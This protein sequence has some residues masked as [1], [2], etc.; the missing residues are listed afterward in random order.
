MQR[1]CDI[2]THLLWVF[3]IQK[4]MNSTLFSLWLVPL[5]WSK[6]KLLHSVD[7]RSRRENSLRNKTKLEAATRLQYVKIWYFI[8]S[9]IHMTEI[10]SSFFDIKFAWLLWIL[11]HNS[12]I[13][14]IDY[15]KNLYP[16]NINHFLKQSDH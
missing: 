15:W 12:S 16:G 5:I 14:W 2:K 9:N 7:E 10:F 8:F 4:C 1:T 13:I 3:A 6:E 11:Y